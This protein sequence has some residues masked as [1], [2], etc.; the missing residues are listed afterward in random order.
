LP[1]LLPL[2]IENFIELSQRLLLG[3]Q[4]IV[5]QEIQSTDRHGERR[6]IQAR[7]WR[8]YSSYSSPNV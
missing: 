5:Q 4:V 1:R 8:R 2:G 3:S 6:G 7:T